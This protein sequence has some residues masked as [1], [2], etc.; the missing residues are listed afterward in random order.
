VPTEAFD[1]NPDREAEP[2]RVRDV[3]LGYQRSMI[4][5]Q[6]GRVN[7]AGDPLRAGQ[8]DTD[9]VTDAVD[10][11]C[12][13]DH[14]CFVRANGQAACLGMAAD[15]ALGDGGIAAEECALTGTPDR[16]CSRS[17]LPVVGVERARAIAAGGKHTCV[18]QRGGAVFCW[19]RNTQGQTGT[20]PLGPTSRATQV[21]GLPAGDPATQL[22]LSSEGSCAL[23]ASGAVWCWGQGFGSRQDS[24]SVDPL[25]LLGALNVAQIA[26][27]GSGLCV[28][29]RSGSV[30]CLGDNDVGQL[31]IGLESSPGSPPTFSLRPSSDVLVSVVG[32]TDARDIGCGLRHCCAT[33]RSGQT[34]CWGANSGSAAG[35]LGTG[36]VEN[37]PVPT[38]V[39]SMLYSL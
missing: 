26:A 13:D 33:R 14:C 10:A 15:E 38:P 19:G 35:A 18:L 8:G 17:P 3:A 28:R 32:L 2:D 27:M 36:D 11:S 12:G 1:V 29:Y 6:D 23:L 4:V 24:F 31:G 9:E 16:R 25:P 21:R 34:V 7:T 30:R 37:R 39:V 20:L 5:R 22:A